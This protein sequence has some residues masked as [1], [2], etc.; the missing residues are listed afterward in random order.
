MTNCRTLE[1]L[2]CVD[3]AAVSNNSSL[4]FRRPQQNSSSRPL[5]DRR[6]VL[7]ALLVGSVS[8]TPPMLMR[9]AFAQEASS[10]PVPS[11][12]VTAVA[13]QA[14]ATSQPLDGSGA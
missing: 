14:G 1:E 5:H 8:L 6:L 11:V 2:L 9:S 13:P 4:D 3:P 7:S 10:T 12:N